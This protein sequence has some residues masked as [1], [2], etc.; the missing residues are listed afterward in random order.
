MAPIRRK[1]YNREMFSED[2]DEKNAFLREY[3]PMLDEVLTTMHE[4]LGGLGSKTKLKKLMEDY[5]LCLANGK[6]Y[7]SIGNLRAVLKANKKGAVVPKEIVKADSCPEEDPYDYVKC[8]LIEVATRNRG[9][10]N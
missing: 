3:L 10:R 7:G 1:V 6:M 9:N 8:C 4:R 2:R 5:G